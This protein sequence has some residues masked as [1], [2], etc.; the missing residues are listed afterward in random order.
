[1]QDSASLFLKKPGRAKIRFLIEKFS[2]L[3]LLMKYV[4]KNLQ[5]PTVIFPKCKVML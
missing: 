1:M 5:D 2:P 3:L 4:V